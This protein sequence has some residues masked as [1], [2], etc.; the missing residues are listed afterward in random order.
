MSYSED[1]INGTTWTYMVARVGRED[2]DCIRLVGPMPAEKI[3]EVLGGDYEFVTLWS[4]ATVAALKERD[5]LPPNENCEGKVNGLVIVGK[6]RG[7][8]FTGAMGT[9]PTGVVLC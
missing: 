7:D 4:D 6:L 9:S 1:T 2:L 5:H 8:A 3:Q